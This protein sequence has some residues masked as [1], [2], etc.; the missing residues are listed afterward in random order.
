MDTGCIVFIIGIVG[1][2]IWWIIFVFLVFG[3]DDSLGSDNDQYF[4]DFV[5]VVLVFACM[6]GCHCVL[7]KGEVYVGEGKS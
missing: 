4:A 2:D 1:A 5:I 3:I 6:G 7:F